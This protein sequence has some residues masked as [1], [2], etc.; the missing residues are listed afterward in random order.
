MDTMN[1]GLGKPL[2]SEDLGQLLQDEKLQRKSLDAAT[3][4]AGTISGGGTSSR[5]WTD[6][7]LEEQREEMALLRIINGQDIR[8]K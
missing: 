8:I 1:R 6:L 5:E 2:S 4:N 3:T 7:S